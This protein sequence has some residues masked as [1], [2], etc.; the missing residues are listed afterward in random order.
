MQSSPLHYGVANKV[1]KYGK[2]GQ[3][4]TTLNNILTQQWPKFGVKNF[5]THFHKKQN[6]EIKMKSQ[7]R[8]KGGPEEADH[9]AKI[10]IFKKKAQNSVVVW[11][12]P[13]GEKRC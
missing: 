5:W 6:G 4:Y 7:K 3:K 2:S 8:V 12:T 11:G 10:G 1:V 13:H 9:T